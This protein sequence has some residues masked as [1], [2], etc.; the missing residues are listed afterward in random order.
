MVMGGQLART[1][2]AIQGKWLPY[3]GDEVTGPR[4]SST[5]AET[6]RSRINRQRSTDCHRIILTKPVNFFPV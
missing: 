1:S 2:P 4:Q 5:K 3:V 6:K